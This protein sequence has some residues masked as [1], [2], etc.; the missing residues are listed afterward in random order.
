MKSFFLALSIRTKLIVLLV[1]IALATLIIS[2]TV[3]WTYQLV[4][5]RN[6]LVEQESATAQLIS[7]DVATA[8]LFNDSRVA[9]EALFQVR[10]DRDV[11]QACLFDPAGRIFAR[12]AATA[13]TQ[14]CPKLGGRPVS[15]AS[16]HMVIRRTI[17]IKG[18]PVGSLVLQISLE[19]MYH[20]LARFAETMVITALIALSIAGLLA[21][22]LQRVI[23]Q[24]I[25]HLTHV[26]TKVSEQGNYLLRA[27]R[28][29]NDETG[30]LIDQFN[31]MMERIHER[32]AQLQ[33]AQDGLEDKVRS[34]TQA[35][36]HEIAERKII[37]RDL[38]TA[39]ISAENA[40]RAKSAF[41]ANMSH[42]LRTPLNAVIGYSEILHED[43]VA[44]AD[45]L[46]AADLE[47]ILS[48]A[49]HLLILISDILDLSRIEAGKLALNPTLL[50]AHYLLR[51]VQPTAE[52]LAKQNQNTLILEDRIDE[53][54]VEVDPLRLRQCLLNL[55]SNACKFTEAGRV[56][57]RTSLESCEGRNFVVWTVADTGI[58]IPPEHLDRLFKTFSQVDDS[59]TRRFGGS[60]L[61]LAIS[62]QLCQA[63]GGF[64]SV[65]SVVGSGSSFSIHM[66]L[67]VAESESMTDAA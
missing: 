23:S 58:G 15:Y 27:H 3:L 37:E 54:L 34:R 55:I 8:L 26:A 30:V 43:A 51:E 63:M 67:A 57:L 59:S 56:T 53:A 40:S 12:F 65:E 16:R 35:L 50:S 38:E 13:Q 7:D 17:V 4:H 48:S 47:K 11:E 24:P 44:N 18:E 29:S 60:G 32:D 42:E 33:R 31:A 10:E 66:P 41:L 20:S 45:A 14:P 28:F 64:I 25:L 6:L 46:M 2:G 1:G 39:R 21:S 49:H 36:E 19:E 62:Q 9:K 61:G 52:V 22:K 5:Y